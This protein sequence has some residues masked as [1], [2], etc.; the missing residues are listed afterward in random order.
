MT[1]SA[2]WRLHEIYLLLVGESFLL[3]ERD[4]DGRPVEHGLCRRTG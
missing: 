4:D 1:G 3:I 2:I